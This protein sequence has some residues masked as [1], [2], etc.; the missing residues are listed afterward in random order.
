VVV[1]DLTARDR[2]AL[3]GSVAAGESFAVSGD[4]RTL[5][6]GG[7]TG[8]LTRWSVSGPGSLHLVGRTTN[9]GSLRLGGLALDY[10]G[11]VA[12][13]P[14]AGN[15][16]AVW[17]LTRGADPV[18]ASLLSGHSAGIRATAVSADG[19]TILT[20]SVDT[21]A[22]V[23]QRRDRTHPVAFALPGPGSAPVTAVSYGHDHHLLLVGRA[24]GGLSLWGGPDPDHPKRQADLVT[25]SAGPA[26]V[27]TAFGGDD[28]TALA[29]DA[30]GLLVTWSIVEP[31]AG[32]VRPADAAQVTPFGQPVF[33]F[34]DTASVLVASAPSGI[35]RWSIDASGH[36]HQNGTSDPVAGYVE[37]LAVSR[38][39]AF[40]LSGDHGGGLTL[41]RLPSQGRPVMMTTIDA[42]RFSTSAVAFSADG[43][44]AVSGGLDES[45][46]RWRLSDGI[47]PVPTAAMGGRYG[48]VAPLGF[49]PD[50]AI[51]AVGDEK[52]LTLLDAVDG[53]VVA[54]T[55][56][57][58][59]ATVPFAFATDGQLLATGGVTPSVWDLGPLT[60]I[61]AD[62][63]SVACALL[64]T[65]LSR[66]QWGARLPSIAYRPSC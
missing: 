2:P 35:A 49:S 17:D 8:E 36:P 37:S 13:T 30:S 45:M 38:D 22:I 1:W 20:A 33:A 59:D 46:K 52:V 53:S 28:R 7:D 40:A 55:T 66:E 44:G 34:N 32:T 10:S 4:G 51:L 19:E 57:H 16:A 6:T 61:V 12:V 5:L 41:W 25:A 15:V 3:A 31:D 43:R 23:W 60:S 14:A 48:R 58:D 47:D 11:R 26:I 63:K 21:T 39:G 24:D 18:R 42:H 27:A 64:G 62:P 29:V 56:E 9:D 54:T 50:G 65:G